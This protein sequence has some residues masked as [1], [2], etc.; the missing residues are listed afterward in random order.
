MARHDVWYNPR[1]SRG[2]RWED[3][4]PRLAWEYLKTLSE[5]QTKKQKDWGCGSSDRELI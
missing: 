4:G 3:C 2:G 1:Y 5:I